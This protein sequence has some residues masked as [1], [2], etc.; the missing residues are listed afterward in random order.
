MGEIM[1]ER[2]PENLVN[3]K[4]IRFPKRGKAFSY[5]FRACIERFGDRVANFGLIYFTLLDELNND[6]EQPCEIVS[7]YYCFERD[8][9]LMVVSHPSLPIVPEGQA[10]EI[11]PVVWEEEIQTSQPFPMV[12]CDG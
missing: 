6:Y 8:A 7:I 4:P 5:C 10:Y 1:G 11:E 3:I 2:G 12:D 9:I